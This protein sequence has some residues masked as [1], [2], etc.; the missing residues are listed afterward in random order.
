MNNIKVNKLCELI[1]ILD[2]K[3]D[4]NRKSK[5]VLS[6]KLKSE[7]FTKD[8]K[9]KKNEA[10][11]TQWVM[12]QRNK[13]Q[14]KPKPKPR[15]KPKSILRPPIDPSDETIDGTDNSIEDENINERPKKK[16]GNRSIVFDPNDDKELLREMIESGKRVD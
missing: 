8:Y 9:G 15:P 6:D 3:F 16:I 4:T 2:G 1:H 5:S 11:V 14:P 13:R 12:Q 10:D 7:L